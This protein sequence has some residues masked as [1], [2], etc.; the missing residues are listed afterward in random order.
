MAQP[1]FLWLLYLLLRR[2]WDERLALKLDVIIA[3]NNY[4]CTIK[5]K[6]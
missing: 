5:S 1:L 4:L 6:Y 3:N 2:Q